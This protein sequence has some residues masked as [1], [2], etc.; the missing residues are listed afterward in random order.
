MKN[1]RKSL[2][3]EFRQFISLMYPVYNTVFD[4][5]WIVDR[6]PYLR[7]LWK[8]R[9]LGGGDYYYDRDWL[10]KEANDEK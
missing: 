8:V 10:R 5:G 6:H 1:K 9:L 4:S 7:H 3:F 2:V